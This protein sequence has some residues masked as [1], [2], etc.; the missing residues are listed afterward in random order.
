M[1]FHVKPP[2]PPIGDWSAEDALSVATYAYNTAVIQHQQHE[3]NEA[4]KA[5]L[6][7]GGVVERDDMLAHIEACDLMGLRASN[8]A[9]LT[10]TMVVRAMERA[11][12][13]DADERARELERIVRAEHLK[14]FW[15]RIRWLVYGDPVPR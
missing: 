14:T 3:K 8:F 6:L 2:L 15:G 10:A 9:V 5:K 13:R 1:A 4:F 11:K 7:E 12:K